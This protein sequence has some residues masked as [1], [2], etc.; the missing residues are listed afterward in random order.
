ML[1][2]PRKLTKGGKVGDRHSTSGLAVRRM[3]RTFLYDQSFLAFI[4]GPTYPEM[5]IL[6]RKRRTKRVQLMSDDFSPSDSVN[7]VVG[8]VKVRESESPAH[9]LVSWGDRSP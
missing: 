1:R 3:N 6:G 9:P 2:A 7:V 4:K 8:G 5:Q